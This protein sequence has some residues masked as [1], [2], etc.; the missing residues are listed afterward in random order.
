MPPKIVR[1]PGIETI[2]LPA[3]RQS[4]P[5]LHG[6]LRARIMDGTLPP[7]TKLSQASLADQLGVS[8]TPLREVL[9]MLQDEGLITAEPNQRMRVAP[10]DPVVLDSDYS[11]RIL[12]GALALMMTMRQFGPAHRRSAQKL[13]TRMRGAARRK[14]VQGWLDTHA[15]FH[16]LFEA[17][18]PEPLQR[19]LQVMSERSVRYVRIRQQDESPQWGDVGELEHPAILEAVA[20]GDEQAAIAALTRHL[21][22]TAL[23]VLAG[24]APEY[25][26]TAVPRAVALIAQSCVETPDLR[27]AT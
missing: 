13:L 4:V 14:D 21:A 17:G 7:G 5:P 19:Q 2:D 11:A 22:G 25:R 9:R 1:V 23:R 27:E 20:D 26:P 18:A 16:A 24:S 15:A 12:L 10:L 6:Y 8:R 3:A